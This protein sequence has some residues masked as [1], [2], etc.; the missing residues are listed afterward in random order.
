MRLRQSFIKKLKLNSIIALIILSTFILSPISTY[1]KTIEEI[2]K[3]IQQKQEELKKLENDLKNSE[4]NIK[5]YEN[6]KTGASSEIASLEIEI[7]QIEEEIKANELESQKLQSEIEI[8]N[9]ELEQ[10]HLV[11][12]DK[13]IDLYIYDRTGYLDAILSSGEFNS[14]SKDLS[15][16]QALMDIDFSEIDNLNELV[17]EKK[18]SLNLFEQSI[19]A[20]GLE[21]ESLQAK[22]TQLEQKIASLNA[23]IAPNKNSQDGIRAKMG[24]VV[25]QIDG[26]NAEYKQMLAEMGA[27][28]GNANSGGNVPLEAGDYY[29]YGIGHYNQGHGLGFSQYGAKGAGQKGWTADNIAKYYFTGSYIGQASGNIDVVGYGSMNIETYLAGLGE[30]PDYACGT[31]EQYN[32][33][34]DK[35]RVYNPNYWE[36]GCWPEETIKAQVIVARS[37]ALAYGGPICTSAACQVYKGGNAK[38]WAANETQGKVLMVGGSTIKAF[39]SSDNNN[40]WGSATHR[41]PVWCW[42][43]AGNCGAGFSWLQSV[44]DES[45]A[46]PGPY[47]NFIWRTNGYSLADFDS[48]FSWY[49]TSG[50]VYASN[51]SSLINTVGNVTG[52]S[53]ER[54]ASGRVAK[55]L[56]NG[57]K[58]SAYVNGEKFQYIYLKWNSATDPSGQ[59]AKDKGH[60]YIYSLTFYFIQN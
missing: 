15:Y 4:E 1:A 17:T 20:I 44:N 2:E 6:D 48:M 22:K 41:K 60:D 7:A 42:D 52:F 54:D 23:Q 36:G 14:Y 33:R 59:Y 50:N 30:V 19:Y 27:M 25:Q 21:N 5:K 39:Y 58:G 46:S 37:Y 43:F 55:V 38:L 8:L 40:G 45:F 53:F 31:Q 57:N 28:F 47:D 26:L 11:V 24:G 34:P 18:D 9:L 49:A 3:E 35:Y 10:N 51:V 56:V 12:S 16:K 13:L 29:F 32:A